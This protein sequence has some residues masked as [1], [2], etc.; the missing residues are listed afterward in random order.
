M[1]AGIFN[2]ASTVGGRHFRANDFASFSNALATALVRSGAARRADGDAP[3]GR[4]V[5]HDGH[6][7]RAFGVGPHPVPPP[8]A[9][10]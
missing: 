7:V 6:T 8:P 3:E 9:R 2:R 5:D 1:V 4:I 10:R